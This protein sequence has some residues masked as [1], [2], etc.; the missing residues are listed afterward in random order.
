MRLNE[1]LID[2]A[3]LDWGDLLSSWAWLLPSELT[4]WLMSRFGDLF[5]VLEDGSVR[6]LD[7]GQGT[8]ERVADNRDECARRIDEDGN[9]RDWLMIPLV[10][11]LVARG[12]VLGAGECYSYAQLPILGGDYAFANVRVAAVEAHYKGLGPIHEK[13]KGI[14]DGTRVR[15]RVGEQPDAEAG[16]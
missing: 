14:P 13:L 11:E 2:H 16:D 9:A 12:V 4:V 10:D 8:F 7:V 6:M 5:C 15:L 1:Y 3:G